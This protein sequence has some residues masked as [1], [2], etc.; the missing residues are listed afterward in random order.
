MTH[1]PTTDFAAAGFTVARS[2]IPQA[3]F[4]PFYEEV[5]AIGRALWPDVNTRTIDDVWLSLARTDRA[6][7]GQLYDAVKHSIALR[8]I[9]CSPPILASIR[10]LM[11]SQAVGL[12]DLNVR[13]DAPAEGKFLFD[14]HQDYWFSICSSQAVV[15]WI[16][17]VE[18]DQKKGGVSLISNEYTGGRIFRVRRNAEYQSYSNSILVDEAVPE[19]HSVDIIP[20]LGDCAFF[21]FN[22]LHK[23]LPNTSGSAC[24]W[25]LQLRFVSFEDEEFRRERFRPGTVTAQKITYLE[26]I[27]AREAN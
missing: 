23:S 25:T 24:R 8:Q 20:G 4:E 5:R 12:V 19:E 2:L 21:K 10:S 11:N 26:R 3:A 6:L 17:L 9:A 18:L 16:P 27:E 14:W 13:I 1:L 22:V 15:A 7:A